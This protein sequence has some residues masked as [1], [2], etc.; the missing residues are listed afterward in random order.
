V[1][2]RDLVRAGALPSRA[3]PELLVGDTARLREEV[4]FTPRWTLEDGLQ[5]TVRW[6]EAQLA[7]R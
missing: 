3:E 5:A 7:P 1:G 6:W 2:R 4:G